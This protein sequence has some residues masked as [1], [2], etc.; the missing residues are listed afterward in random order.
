MTNIF[1]FWP[2]VDEHLYLTCHRMSPCVSELFIC[3]KCMK[4]FWWNAIQLTT[5]LIVSSSS[6]SFLNHRVILSTQHV[7]AMLWSMAQLPRGQLRMLVYVV[8]SCCWCDQLSV[9]VRQI[10]MLQCPPYPTS[11]WKLCTDRL[12][13]AVCLE[14][15]SVFDSDLLIWRLLLGPIRGDVLGWVRMLPSIAS[16][17]PHHQGWHISWTSMS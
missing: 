17:L 2:T 4:L 14:S 15:S 10:E 11:S 1:K 8:G 7:G 6:S 12:Q 16:T 3:I 13:F 9:L 5:T